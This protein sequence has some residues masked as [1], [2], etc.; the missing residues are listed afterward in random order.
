MNRM[1]IATLAVALAGC[2]AAPNDINDVE[3]A[4]DGKADGVGYPAGTY[5]ED[6]PTVGHVVLLTLNADHSFHAESSQFCAGGGTCP[7]A[8]LDGSYKFTRS[9]TTR[10]IRLIDDGGQLIDRYA[11]TLTGNTLKVRESSSTE[12]IE[13][14]KDTACHGVLPRICKQCDDGTSACAHFDSSC[15]IVT[16]ESTGGQ[17]GAICGPDIVTKCAAGLGCQISGVDTG[18]CQPQGAQLGQLCGPDIVNGQCGPGLTCK[19]SGVD[20]GT[21]QLP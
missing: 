5:R 7:N 17:A 20:T 15:N 21:C 11:W 6:P 4:V 16:C 1:M 2:T 8:I 10:Y 3:D 13:L 14:Q 12:T 19:I 18:T 9:S